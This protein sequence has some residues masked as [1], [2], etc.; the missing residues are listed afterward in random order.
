MGV[1]SR[2]T[3]RDL[4]CWSGLRRALEHFDLPD[5]GRRRPVLPQH[6]VNGLYG[7]PESDQ[8]SRC[9]APRFDPAEAEQAQLLLVSRREARKRALRRLERRSLEDGALLQCEPLEGMLVDA[10]RVDTREEGGTHSEI[11]GDRLVRVE[12]DVTE[13]RLRA[14]DGSVA[15][16]RGQV[17][18][19]RNLHGRCAERFQYRCRHARASWNPNLRP[20]A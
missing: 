11:P 3:C 17:S 18:T 15:E 5:A 2:T 12:E 19:A 13:R 8:L 14:V 10:D 9:R 20:L 6:R 4:K 16:S 7:V 1:S